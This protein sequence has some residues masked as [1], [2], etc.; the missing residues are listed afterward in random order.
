MKVLAFISALSLILSSCSGEANKEET[1]NDLPK[2]DGIVTESGL[3]VVILEEGQGEYPETGDLVSVHY[4]GSLAY[5]GEVFD[6][7]YDV[8]RPFE[9]PLGKGRVIPGWDEGIA[10]LNVGTKAKLIIPANL[11]YGD[12]DNGPI[13]AKSDLVFVVELM[14]IKAAPKPILHEVFDTLSAEKIVTNSGLVCYII[15][16]GE[17]TKVEVGSNVK[18]HYYGYLTENDQKFDSSFERGEPIQ[19]QVGAGQVIPGWE[20]G[21]ALLSQGDKAKL[22]IPSGLAYGDQGIPGVIPGGAE[23][24]F[25]VQVMSGQ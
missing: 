16:K 25:D 13:P 12:K 8:G 21:L 15:E 23:L 3:K 14:G 7:S 11:A 18:V 1:E 5:N 19:V 6:S 2:T 10:K 9:F 22:V 24:A 20:E 17:G 4:T